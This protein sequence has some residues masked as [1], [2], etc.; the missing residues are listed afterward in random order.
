LAQM[1]EIEYAS[2]EGGIT[3][4]AVNGNNGNRGSR[5]YPVLTLSRALEAAE[6]RG[7]G[8]LFIMGDL[9]LAPGDNITSYHLI[10]E[11][12]SRTKITLGD[13]CVT[14]GATLE[15]M[16][17]EGYCGGRMNIRSCDIHDIHRLC[18][19]NG[20][21]DIRDCHLSGVIQLNA[22]ADEMFDFVDCI[23]ESGALT[24]T[25]DI[26]GCP[27]T[28][29][30]SRWSGNLRLKNGTSAP[31]LVSVDLDSGHLIL[32][33]TV[34]AGGYNL[35]GLAKLSNETTPQE[36]LAIDTSGLQVPVIDQYSET[37]Y[38]D[39]AGSAG[40]DY[41][42]G[43]L[44]AAVNN[45]ADMVSLAQKFLANKLH[46]HSDATIAAGMD[47]SHY[48]LEAHATFKHLI[49]LQTGCVMGNTVLRNIKLTGVLGGW[50][51]FDH[52]LMV[53]VSEV[54]GNINSAM[55]EGTISLKSD[56]SVYVHMDGIRS[57]T[58][59]VVNISVGLAEVNCINAYG[60][61]AIKNKVGSSEFNMHCGYGMVV[62]D[63]SCTAGVIYAAGEGFIQNNAGAGCMVICN[64]RVI[65]ND[66]V[67]YPQQVSPE[68][69]VD[70][71]A[72][73]AAVRDELALELAGIVFLL[74]SITNRREIKKTGAVWYLL[75]YDNDGVAVVLSKALKDING[76]NITDLAAGNLALELASA[77]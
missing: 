72:I 47:V 5:Q 57:H 64:G 43:L 15:H 73:A 2:F 35:R 48:S 20:N 46:F 31:Q 8:K 69:S 55:M 12:K 45:V 10:G 26:N 25:I 28:L 49:T 62:V 65:P 34:V 39:V 54:W 32:E 58:Q 56:P 66:G 37:I 63:S 71:A 17:V 38:F 9:T 50:C 18:A 21:A 23:G 13:G 67:M 11:D 75:V 77:A 19:T 70:V 52:V 44:S 74:K 24:P 42:H 4:D 22:A 61:F 16:E 3:L 76:N 30:I 29:H 36:D 53:D 59:A 7:L 40:A 33:D 68:V 27:A 51:T 60:M 41:P 1:P 6:G 14:W